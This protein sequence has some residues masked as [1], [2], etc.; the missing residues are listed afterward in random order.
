[1]DLNGTQGANT[2]GYADDLAVV[3]KKQDDIDTVFKA[4]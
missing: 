1:M 2:V 4:Y 3:I